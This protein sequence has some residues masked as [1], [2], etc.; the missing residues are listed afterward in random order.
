VSTTNDNYRDDAALKQQSRDSMA[1]NT[2]QLCN[3]SQ[4]VQSSDSVRRSVGVSFAGYHAVLN[5]INAVFH[6]TMGIM[7]VLNADYYAAMGI[8]YVI[9]NCVLI[10]RLTSG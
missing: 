10:F 2:H 1:I 7:N 9:I 4:R 6:A 5:A 8:I 3:I